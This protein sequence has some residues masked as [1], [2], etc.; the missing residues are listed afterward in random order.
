VDFSAATI[1]LV[2]AVFLFAGT[3]KGLIGVGLPTIAIALLIL[4]MPVRDAI[5]LVVFPAIAT[6]IWQAVLGGH[7]QETLKRFWPLYVLLAVG[8]WIGVGILTV[9]NPK[10]ISGLFGAILTVYA[11]MGLARPG[12]LAVGAAERWLT[13]LVGILNG[14]VNGMTG[15]YILPGT[16]YLQSL[17]LPRDALIQS[18]GI[19][20]LVASSS[21]GIALTGH[22]AMSRSQ[23]IL[24]AAI[25]LPTLGG[26]AFGQHFRRRLPEAEFR[27]V[28]F[29]GLMLLGAYTLVASLL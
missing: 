23:A 19:L 5:P 1:A 6:N 8:T 16:L 26:Y 2:V 22:S 12:P 20:F 14:L 11:L 7:G 21:L 28:F 13:P 3:V 24:S 27:R 10:L 18:M 4:V 29:I 25:L 15:S 17:G 9:G